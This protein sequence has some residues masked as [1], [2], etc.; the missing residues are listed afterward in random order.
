MKRN[1]I[2]ALLVGVVMIC[3]TAGQ[4]AQ[5]CETALLVIDM[6]SDL[7][8]FAAQSMHTL[9]KQPILERVEVIVGS[10]RTAGIP[11]IYLKI[12]SAAFQSNPDMIRICASI[13]P[14]DSEIV[15]ARTNPDP[16]VDTELDSLLREQGIT[17]LLI[18]GIYST[19][20]VDTT[21]RSSIELGYS[22]IVIQDGHG[23][24]VNNLAGAR[25]IQDEWKAM[26]DV[27]VIKLADLSLSP[28]CDL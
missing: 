19:C 20:C 26:A 12:I 9:F 16:F 11:V 23:D 27:S 15:L 10:A 21:V 5:S 2:F 24:H 13:A 28:L 6:Q 4:A 7:L 18:C 22:V 14:T 17:Q 25:K 8:G 3:T 1:V